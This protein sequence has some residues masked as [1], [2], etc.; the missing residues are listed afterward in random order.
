MSISGSSERL[1]TGPGRA[2]R[3]Q[4]AKDNLYTDKRQAQRKRE[5]EGKL[6]DKDSRSIRL[7]IQPEQRFENCLRKAAVL[8]NDEI[9][10]RG[11]WKK[12]LGKGVA[13]F[14]VVGC[15]PRK[16][17]SSA[18]S[19]SRVVAKLPIQLGYCS[20]IYLQCSRP[21]FLGAL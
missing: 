18:L 3:A 8:S 13:S 11:Q 20:R 7:R 15:Q 17:F 14:C 9:G 1:S 19:K 21:R 10:V 6:S 4:S 5:R 16:G 2:S 12:R